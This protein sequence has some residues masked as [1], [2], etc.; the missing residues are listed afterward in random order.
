MPTFVPLGGGDLA[1]N[2]VAGLIGNN[3]VDAFAVADANSQTG[4]LLRHLIGP[5]F[6]EF[7]SLATM[8]AVAAS[9]G[10]MNAVAVS[11]TARNAIR[12][13]STAFNIVAGS[14][15]AIGKFVAGEAGL[16]PADYAD[17]NA[18]VASA[19][20]MDA[21]A[22]SATAMN[23]VAASATAMNIALKSSI[24]RNAMAASATARSAIISKLSTLNDTTKFSETTT[25]VNYQGNGTDTYTAPADSLLHITQ[26]YAYDQDPQDMGAEG[27]VIIT[28]ENGNY[29]IMNRSDIKAEYS[30]TTTVTLNDT[31]IGN[32]IVYRNVSGAHLNE[33]RAKVSFTIYTAI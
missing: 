32:F 26:F 29:Q 14:N 17:M 3:S 22:A 31:S 23:A 18:I 6:D 16:N 12:N 10:V 30:T 27:T 4:K 9:A 7:K 8:N 24:A 13:S 19:T 28:A 21:V 20:A 1:G 25:Y 2:L 33:F 5:A 15:M 11:S